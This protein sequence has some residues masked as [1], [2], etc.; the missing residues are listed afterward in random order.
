LQRQGGEFDYQ[1]NFLF[2]ERDTELFRDR[3]MRSPTCAKRFVTI[4]VWKSCVMDE[5][6][7]NPDVP[8]EMLTAT[9]KK[10]KGIRIAACPISNSSLEFERLYVYQDVRMVSL[11]SDLRQYSSGVRSGHVVTN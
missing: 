10:E 1:S 9:G 3:D 7:V 2:P 6:R 8:T 5:L 11:Y 4:Q